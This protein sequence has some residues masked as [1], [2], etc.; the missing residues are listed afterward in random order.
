MTIPEAVE[1]LIDR[2]PLAEANFFSIVINIQAKAGGNLAEALMNLSNVLRDRKKMRGKIKA[3]S[4]EAK[5]SAGI[6][7]CL[8]PIVGSA[9]YFT[10][11]GYMTLLFSTTTGH[12]VLGACAIW[13]GI[14]VFV[15]KKMVSFEI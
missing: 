5:A 11:P 14:G 12:L 4:S 13:M 3:M 2:V 10:S 1:R 15:M 9:V 8:P 7:G 6:I